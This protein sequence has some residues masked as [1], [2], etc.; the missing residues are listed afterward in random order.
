MDWFGEI[1][2]FPAFCQSLTSFAL[3]H[4]IAY[5]DLYVT[6][7]SPDLL[8][9]GELKP[10]SESVIIPNYLEPLVLKNVEISYMTSAPVL[11]FFLRGDG[12]QDRPSNLNS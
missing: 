7:V 2:K 1:A 8:A 5:V 12:D 9:I 6:G 10:I 3:E 11:P 4:D